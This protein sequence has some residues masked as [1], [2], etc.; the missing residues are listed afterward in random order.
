MVLSLA[1]AKTESSP[2]SVW[3]SRFAGRFH[4]NGML[5]SE[6]NGKEH[7]EFRMIFPSD[8]VAEQS[9]EKN[10]ERNHC[11]IFQDDAV[12]RHKQLHHI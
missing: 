4:A 8:L 3:S 12:C 1:I 11:L 2:V 9:E 5:M 10:A 6:C 7:E